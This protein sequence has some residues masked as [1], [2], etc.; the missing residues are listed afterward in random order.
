MCCDFVTWKKVNPKRAELLEKHLSSFM[1]DKRQM[2]GCP[3]Y[4]VNTNLFASVH[5]DS[6]LIRLKEED[7]EVLMKEY[8]EAHLFEPFPGRKMREYIVLPE[9]IVSNSSLFSQWLSKAF[10]YA[11]SLPPKKK[12]VKKNSN[13]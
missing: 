8:K 2:F 1:C 6:I 4:F 9:I 12:K 10:D 7:R 13:L 3:A 5:Q 11:S